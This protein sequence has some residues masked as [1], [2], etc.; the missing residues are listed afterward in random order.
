[1]LKSKKSKMLSI[2]IATL[3]AG[4][5]LSG[6]GSS[7][8]S[9]TTSKSA[10]IIK[11]NLGAN[12]K[13]IDPGLNSSVEGATVIANAF[14]GL[15]DVDANNKPHPGVAKSWTISADGKHYVFHLRKDAKWSDG[16]PVTAKDFEYAWKR[17]L[18]PETASDYAYQLYYLK[19][20]Q[21]YNESSLPADQKTPGVAA[22]TADQVGVK[23]TDDYTLDVELENPTPYFLSLMAFQTYMPLRKD[24][25]DAHPKDWAIN[26]PT[27]VS[28]GAFKMVDWKQKDKLEFVK[29]PNY[30]NKSAVKLDKLTYT[31]LDDETSY[32]SAYQ[33]G[34]VDIIDA[35]PTEQIPSLLKSGKAKSYV[36]IGTYYYSFN[37][38]PTAK[39][40]PAVAKAMDNVKVRQA[41]SLAIDR[42]SLVKNVTKAGQIPSTTF[43]PSGII[44]P[45]GKDFKQKKYYSATADVKKAKQLL[46]DAGYADGNNFPSIEL[47]YNNGE[48]HQSVA[49]AIQAMLKKN[50]NINITLRSVERKVQLDETSKHTYTGMARNGWSADYV[51][52][53]TFLDM[54]VTGGGNNTAGYSNKA[55]DKLIEEAK[56]ETNATK[57]FKEMHDAEDILMTDMPIIPL[58]EYNVIS[59]MKDYVKGVYRTPMDTV[60]FTNAYVQK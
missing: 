21:G 36:N 60:Y 6:C 17:A 22:A 39:V 27:Y 10:Q 3:V 31:V 7:S 34:Q 49:E 13:T 51:D 14:E 18:A 25:I 38:D 42:T 2:A 12:P 33:S 54:W 32:M 23:A 50:L 44:G 24:V 1:M 26:G 58:Y 41:I 40:D 19:N 5:L 55:Y 28:N 56:A 45:D 16:K 59:C 8:S 52:P 37:L 11:Y 53:M 29:N 15:T 46:A 47:I 43:V 57:R 4:S 20:A 9:S 48:G 30:W 35:P